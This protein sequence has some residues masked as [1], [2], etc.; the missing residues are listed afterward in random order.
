M[1]TIVKWR[2][3]AHHG[4]QTQNDPK[5]LAASHRRSNLQFFLEAIM[6]QDTE[7]LILAEGMFK[8]L[9]QFSTTGSAKCGPFSAEAE[10]KEATLVAA[11]QQ[12]ARC[13][14]QTLIFKTCSAAAPS[15]LAQPWGPALCLA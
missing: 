5:R 13:A 6:C 9:Q 8:Q 3:K 11:A 4:W 10:V 12:A 7:H 14:R 1:A 2:R 15:K